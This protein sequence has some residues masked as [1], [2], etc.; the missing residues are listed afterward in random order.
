ML[1]LP[2]APQMRLS[3]T[4]RSQCAPGPARKTPSAGTQTL[5]ASHVPGGPSAKGGVWAPQ[6]WAL[7][8]PL[9]LAV[10]LG[11]VANSFELH[12]PH[13]KKRLVIATFEGGCGKWMTSQM[14]SACGALCWVTEQQGFS[15]NEPIRN[16]TQLLVMELQWQW[17]KT[18][19]ADSPKQK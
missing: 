3:P 12:F 19:G 4:L 16:C 11:Q 6:T 1:T 14:R 15:A 8:W 2:H 17:L 18:F 7:S 10:S 13:Q 9:L 5:A